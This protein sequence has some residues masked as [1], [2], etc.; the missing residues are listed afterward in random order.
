M[1]RPNG[2]TQAYSCGTKSEISEA[3]CLPNDCKKLNRAPSAT[4]FGV[5]CVNPRHAIAD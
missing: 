2:I 3:K 5:W 1:A 4:R